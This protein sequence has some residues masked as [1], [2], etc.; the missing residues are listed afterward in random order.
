MLN[1]IK[2]R[3][4]LKKLGIFSACV[5]GLGGVSYGCMNRQQQRAVLNRLGGVKRFIRSSYTVSLISFDYWWSLRDVDEDSA[6]YPTLLG[7]VHQ[8]SADRILTMCLTNGGLYIKLGQG[9]VSLDHVLP[10]QYP[11]TLRAL[12]DKCLLRKRGEVDQ[13][14]LEDFGC[15][16][17]ELFESFD[18]NPIAAASLAQVF[19]AVTKEGVE[20]AVKVQYIDLRDR[21]VGDI[22]TVQALLRIAGYLYPKFDFEWVVKELKGPLEQELDFL[23][24]GKNAERCSKDLAHLPYVYI[25]NILW[26]KSST[27][28]LTTEFIHGYKV[29]DKERLLGEGFCLADVDRKLFT[30]F[31][32]QIF[33]TGFVHADP[34]PGNV[35]VRRGGDK[36]AQL[37][38]LDHGLY[39]EVPSDIRQSLCNL[40]K[41]IVLNNHEDMRTYSKLLG[42]NETDYR[43]FSIAIGQRYI[44]KDPRDTTDT[45]LDI[46]K[47]LFTRNSVGNQ[48]RIRFKDL[49]KDEQDRLRA[50]I[51]A[52]HDRTIEIFKSVPS[53]LMLVTRNINTIRSIAKGHGNPVDRY[54]IM[55]RSATQGVFKSESSSWWSR[56][57]CLLA[58]SHFEFMLWWT[59][60]RSQLLNI[61]LKFYMA[62][63]EPLVSEMMLEG[64]AS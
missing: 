10:R 41:A 5:T 19:K 34:H 56:L 50:E 61:Y 47:I 11:N 63:A 38:I 64:H 35:L 57:K 31:G 48:P 33:H 18:E 40:W 27:R 28:V 32:E 29:S 42:V 1:S 23:N 51:L 44:S 24:E 25:P 54:S 22:A 3:G 45:G 36:K 39:E 37:V 26:D 17:S 6:A 7:Q 12:Q 15:T 60:F 52:V 16:H 30:A 8:R 49:A 59:N 2:Q 13:L 53:K 4:R 55:A 43:L 58:L 46:Y 62:T 21:F 9:L 14:F 20:V